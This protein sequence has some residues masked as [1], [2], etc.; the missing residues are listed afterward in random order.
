[1]ALFCGVE[2]KNDI[3]KTDFQEEIGFFFH[4]IQSVAERHHNG[5]NPILLLSHCSKALAAVYGSV[6]LGLEGDLGFATAVGTYGSE[7][8]LLR[9]ACVLSGVT[10]CLAA[11]GL[12]LEASLG[13]ELLLAGGEGELL[14]AVLTLQNLVFVHFATSL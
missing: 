1:M 9:L 4:K 11:L 6:V 3:L 14:S 5:R 13:I 10:A 7:E 8:L 2:Q 12:V